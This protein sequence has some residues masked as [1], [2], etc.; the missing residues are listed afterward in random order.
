MEKKSTFLKNWRSICGHKSFAAKG[1]QKANTKSRQ[2]NAS[3]CPTKTI[4]K[5][6]TVVLETYFSSSFFFFFLFLPTAE[7]IARL[8]GKIG[9]NLS[10]SEGLVYIYAH[11]CTQIYVYIS[12]LLPC[13]CR[14]QS[15]S[16]SPY[17]R[18]H[19]SWNRPAEASSPNT[20]WCT[21]A[22]AAWGW[23][24][25]ALSP[26]SGQSSGPADDG[27][28]VYYIIHCFFWNW[29][30]YQHH[31]HHHLVYFCYSVFFELEID[32]NIWQL[33]T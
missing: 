15:R 28:D 20:W 11:I 30:W 22:R 23:S 4:S 18:G 33:W 27:D 21:R 2:T 32:S 31:Y 19:G 12:F 13:S 1:K 16:G 29:Y 26:F 8:M 17:R 24:D 7:I 14:K 6:D 25:G 5:T 9:T 3:R 10:A